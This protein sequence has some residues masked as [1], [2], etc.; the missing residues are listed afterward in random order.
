VAEVGEKLRIQFISLILT[1]RNSE[2]KYFSLIAVCENLRGLRE[3]IILP[4]DFA[5]Y[6]EKKTP[7]DSTF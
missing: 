2:S 5:K 4:A 3:I 6:A 1:K 7:N